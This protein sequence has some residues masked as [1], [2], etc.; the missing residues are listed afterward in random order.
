MAFKNFAN[1]KAKK[2]SKEVKELKS[3]IRQYAK[4]A[5][6]R[7]RELEKQ[8]L[9]KGSYAYAKVEQEFYDKKDYLTTGTH[10]DRKTGKTSKVVKYKTALSGMS[11]EELK[12]EL[13]ALE[14]FLKSRTSS[15]T[16]MYDVM[17]KQYEAYKQKTGTNPSFKEFSDIYS[18]ANVQNMLNIFGSDTVIKLS[19]KF[20]ESK[21]T[22]EN[23]ASIMKQIS[24]TDRQGE[25]HIGITENVTTKKDHLDERNSY[26]TVE[27]A[28]ENFLDIGGGKNDN[29]Q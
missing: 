9:E 8:G 10:T 20:G 14:K 1:K 24:W 6:Q 12:E 11:E 16:G 26:R 25:T 19:K 13:K 15:R 28:F 7:L 21:V 2:E 18:N 3:K 5:N 4:T 29:K 22:S 27:K 17:G 23:L